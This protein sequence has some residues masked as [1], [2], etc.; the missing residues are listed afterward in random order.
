MGLWKTHSVTGTKASGLSLTR[1]NRFC[2]HDQP[3]T[4]HTLMV[5]WLL[6]QRLYCVQGH[7]PRSGPAL[8]RTMRGASGEHSTQLALHAGLVRKK[9]RNY[10]GRAVFMRFLTLR[11][12]RK[13][14]LGYFFAATLLVG[15][16]VRKCCRKLPPGTQSVLPLNFHCQLS[17]AIDGVARIGIAQC[18]QQLC[19]SLNMSERLGSLSALQQDAPVADLGNSQLHHAVDVARLRGKH[20]LNLRDRLAETIGCLGAP[21]HC[22]FGCADRN[23]VSVILFG[24]LH[25]LRVLCRQLC[26]LVSSLLVISEGVRSAAE[27]WKSRAASEVSHVAQADRK[28]TRLNSSHA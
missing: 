19:G 22:C 15:L 13:S 9:T 18:P 28:S 12:P 20:V 1:P 14:F 17:L 4:L 8:L 24:D 6:G 26:N 21:A 10:N 23:E 27:T 3:T 7:P 2:Q 16:I 11:T 25:V 5:H